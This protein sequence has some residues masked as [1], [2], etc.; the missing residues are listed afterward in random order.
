M[1]HWKTSPAET[2]ALTFT[3]GKFLALS[4]ILLIADE[5]HG[6]VP[7]YYIQALEVIAS[8][9]LRMHPGDTAFIDMYERPLF[10]V[11][12]FYDTGIIQKTINSKPIEQLT[13]S[14]NN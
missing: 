10:D 13:E 4:N 8:P 3:L 7:G 11:T 6:C 14:A 9:T 5:I 2:P 12:N 1:E